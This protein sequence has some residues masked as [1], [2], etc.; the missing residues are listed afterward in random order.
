MN[1]DTSRLFDK[2]KSSRIAA[3]VFAL[4]PRLPLAQ[5][6]TRYTEGE[7]GRSLAVVPG[8]WAARPHVG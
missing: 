7:V 3:K 5:P 8:S 4:E 2:P 6:A 1:S